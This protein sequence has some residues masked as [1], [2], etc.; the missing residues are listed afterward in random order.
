MWIMLMGIVAML[1]AVLTLVIIGG[2]ADKRLTVGAVVRPSGDRPEGEITISIEPSMS[3]PARQPEWE[4]IVL[5]TIVLG[6][7]YFDFD[8]SAIRSDALPVLAHHAQL[9]RDNRG[10]QVRIEGHCDERGTSEYNLALGWRRAQAAHAYLL[11]YGIAARR[12]SMVSYGEEQP[13]VV[14]HTEE[15]WAAN[16][17][18]AFLVEWGE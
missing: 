15:A 17:R 6:A 4:P 9:L 14:E 12:L 5:P 8:R 1:M 16:R 18:A 10:M 11:R 3:P 2:C 13:E 7:I